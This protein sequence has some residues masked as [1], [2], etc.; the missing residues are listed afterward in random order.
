MSL[1][2]ITILLAYVAY[3]IS[4]MMDLSSQMSKLKMEITGSYESSGKEELS[5]Q[6]HEAERLAEHGRLI[7]ELSALQTQMTSMKAERVA[8]E[9]KSAQQQTAY[10]DLLVKHNVLICDYEALKKAQAS[11]Q[12]KYDDETKECEKFRAEQVN[13]M[14]IHEG[15][16]AEHKVLLLDH[17]MLKKKEAAAH[18]MYDEEKEKHDTLKTEQM[19]VMSTQQDL[20]AQHN[21]LLS[22]YETLKTNHNSI[23]IKYSEEKGKHDTLNTAHHDLQKNY[24]DLQEKLDESTRSKLFQTL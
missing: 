22:N 20:L 8:L 18:K 13:E 10:E 15:L 19:K 4:A 12:N 1:S 24:T 5:V 16:L 21:A 11:I 3:S 6:E 2:A 9:T 14:L 7:E 23:Q 17:E